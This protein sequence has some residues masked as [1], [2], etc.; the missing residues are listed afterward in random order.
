[1]FQ[2]DEIAQP[3]REKEKYYNCKNS[4]KCKKNYLSKNVCSKNLV[5]NYPDLSGFIRPRA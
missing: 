1:M 3:N 5:L 2:I 4:E